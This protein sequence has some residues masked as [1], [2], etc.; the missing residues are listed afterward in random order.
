[1][2][3]D[4][5]PTSFNHKEDNKDE[6]ELR[7]Q[8][9]EKRLSQ[10]EKSLKF[11]E[12]I[13]NLKEQERKTEYKIDQTK[14]DEL[15]KK[16]DFCIVN[17]NKKTTNVENNVDLK[18]K[19]K[20]VESKFENKFEDIVNLLTEFNKEIDLKSN[21]LDD[22]KETLINIQED[23][24]DFIK[25]MSIVKERSDYIEMI[26]EEINNI[27]EKMFSEAKFEEEKERIDDSLKENKIKKEEEKFL[28][29][30]FSSEQE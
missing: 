25:I 7:L 12:D 3:L 14:L 19:I 21:K 1:M 27:K 2:S 5:Y 23:H 15:T 18:Q 22:F 29:K 17:L 6:Y 28:N 11:F 24:I 8:R 30:I 26:L 16:I 10:I 20:Q 4:N 9:I 13:F